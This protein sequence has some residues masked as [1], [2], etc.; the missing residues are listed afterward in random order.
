MSHTSDTTK[1]NTM[2]RK[3][4]ADWCTQRGTRADKSWE[5]FLHIPWDFLRA[6]MSSWNSTEPKNP[7]QVHCVRV[8]GHSEPWTHQV[9]DTAGP[10]H[11][12]SWTKWALDTSGHGHSGP[13][14]HQVMDTAGPG[15]VRSWTKW[16]LNT[17]GQGYS[18]PWTLQ[19]MDTAG[20]G[21]VRSWT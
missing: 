11:V 5:H 3:L 7:N 18:G 9:M 6:E 15:H 19:V 12:R 2:P 21:H 14:T 4:R 16:A 20:P 13:W 10:G 8:H 17:S 1:A